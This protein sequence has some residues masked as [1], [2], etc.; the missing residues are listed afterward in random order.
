MGVPMEYPS[1]QM[2]EFPESAGL[3]AVLAVQVVQVHNEEEAIVNH[4]NLS[5]IPIA[6][7]L[8]YSTNLPWWRNMESADWIVLLYIM[9][10]VYT[11]IVS[12][13][14]LCLFM[15]S[16]CANGFPTRNHL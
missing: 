7:D 1:H 11:R 10:E 12:M 4:R 16:L 6:D 3:L 2:L 5:I 8:L 15:V 13:S 9:L 14:F